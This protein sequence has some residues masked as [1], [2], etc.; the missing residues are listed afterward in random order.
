MDLKQIRYFLNLAETL[1]FTEAARLSDVS[2]PTLTKAIQ[3][4]EEELGGSLVYRDGKDTRLT[5]LGR[6]IRVELDKI[7]ASEM[8]ARELAERIVNEDRAVAR[9]GVAQTIGARLVMRFL[10]GFFQE[11]PRVEVILEPIDPAHAPELV[12]AG[13]FDACFCIDCRVSNPKLDVAH[14]YREELRLAVG[15]SHPLADAVEVPRGVIADQP[16]IDRDKCEFRTR[17]I[18]YFMEHDITMRPRLRSDREDWVQEAVA[19]GLGVAIVPAYSDVRQD[20]RLV[21]VRGLDLVRQISLLTVSGS[22]TSPIAKRLRDAAKRSNWR[23]EPSSV[24]A[25]KL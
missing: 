24:P 23:A 10:A 25:S 5:E 4:L 13:A 21:R 15:C 7:V 12:L 9:I 3:R 6:T 11:M 17:L 2:Q 14:L 18:D 16:Y 19:H 1:N 22:A 8:R 20:L